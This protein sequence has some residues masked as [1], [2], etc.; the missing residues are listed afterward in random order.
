VGHG[1]TEAPR[2][3]LYVRVE[4][5]DRGYVSAIRIVPPTTQNQACIEGDLRELAPGVLALPHEEARRACEMAIRSYAPCISCSTH[6]LTLE[7]ER[8]SSA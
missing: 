4:T 2:G 6:F 1:A 8:R 5:D 3:L 7:I